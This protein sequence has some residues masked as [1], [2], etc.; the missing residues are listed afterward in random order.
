ML[1]SI[2]PEIWAVILTNAVGMF[3]AYSRASERLA[4]LETEMMILAKILDRRN[5]LGAN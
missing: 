1:A 3:V 2:P 4:R 5:D